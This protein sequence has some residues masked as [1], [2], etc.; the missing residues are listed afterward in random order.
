MSAQNSPPDVT[1][2]VSEKEISRVLPRISF[3]LIMT[4]VTAVAALAMGVRLTLLGSP[5]AVGIVYAAATLLLTLA[6]FAALFLVAWVPAVFGRDELED[7]HLGS[8]FSVDQLPPQVLPPRD[9]G[10]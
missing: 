9:P 6:V 2:S 3:R 4:F 1:A 7:V 8:P 5:L 10:T